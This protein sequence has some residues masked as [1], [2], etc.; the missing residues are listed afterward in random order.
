MTYDTPA[1]VKNRRP[2]MKVER[3]P[4]PKAYTHIRREQRERNNNQK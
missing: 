3:K 2:S 4:A 1:I